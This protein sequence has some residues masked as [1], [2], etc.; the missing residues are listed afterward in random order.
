MGTQNQTPDSQTQQPN[1]SGTGKDEMQRQGG[2]K[3]GQKGQDAG[4][5]ARSDDDVLDEASSEGTREDAAGT[6]SQSSSSDRNETN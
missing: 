5:V 6:Q 2:S 1:R 4:N 3:K